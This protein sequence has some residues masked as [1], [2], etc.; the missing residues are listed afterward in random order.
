MWHW[1]RLM[2]G[3]FVAIAAGGGAV[4]ADASRLALVVGNSAN[5]GLPPLPL[6]ALGQRGLAALNGGYSTS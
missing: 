4:A 2:A 5:T 6:A 1:A 3:L